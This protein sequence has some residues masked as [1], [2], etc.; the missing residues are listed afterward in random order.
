M[1]RMGW[2]ASMAV[3]AAAAATVGLVVVPQVSAAPGDCNDW[4]FGNQS[5][6]IDISSGDFLNFNSTGGKDVFGPAEW[7]ND[8]KRWPGNVEAHISGMNSISINF[9]DSDVSW[10]LV[11]NIGPDGVMAGNVTSI[12]GATFRAPETPLTC[13][14]R[15]EEPAPLQGPTVS[16]DPTIG[17]LRVVVTDRSG[18]ASQCTYT[19]DNG[20]TRSFGLGAN[21]T[22]NI[23]IVPAVREFRDWN[24]SVEC[25][26][27]TRT[28][29]TT[30]F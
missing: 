30:F 20:F 16:F 22:T 1:S 26:N 6:W 19:A 12:P 13:N 18:V 9:T 8:A 7:G 27:G 10:D 28:D 24:V 15:E 5:V 29:V 2:T 11:G 4:V 21:A 25:D 23:D 14:I 17:G 3:A